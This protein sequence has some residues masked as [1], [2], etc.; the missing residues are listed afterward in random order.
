MFKDIKNVMC[1]KRPNMDDTSV[2]ASLMNTMTGQ[3]I[4]IMDD[5]EVCSFINCILGGVTMS[6]P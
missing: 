4:P 6:Q 3:M 1:S 5:K 2:K